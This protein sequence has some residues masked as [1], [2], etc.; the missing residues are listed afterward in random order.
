MKHAGNVFHH[1]AVV[2]L[3]AVIAAFLLG[4]LTKPKF[5]N[6]NY[7]PL[8]VTYQGFYEMEKDSVDVLFLGSSHA[9]SSFSPQELYN[10]CGIRSFNLSS[11][12][13]SLLVSYYWLKE[14][15]RTQSVKAVVLDT[16]VLFPYMDTPY[17]CNESAVRKALDPMRWS[18]VKFAAVRDL[19]RLD[20]QETLA[21][22]L[23]PVIRYHARWNDLGPNDI[24]FWP[25]QN[26]SLKGY[27]VLSEDSG[28][29]DFK[30]VVISDAEPAGTNS[31]MMEY[32]DKITAL[33]KEKGIELILVS[34]PYSE[35]T[36][37]SHNA[38]AAYASQNGLTF[39]NFNEA[40]VYD[41][42]DFDFAHDMADAGHANTSGAV[43]LTDYIGG[44]L[45]EK[46]IDSAADSQYETSRAYC[47][48]QIK[49][50]NLYRIQ[51][52]N[53]FYGELDLDEYLIFVTGEGPEYA[54]M[55]NLPDAVKG[56][57]ASLLDGDAAET[58]E[59]DHSSWRMKENL[60]YKLHPGQEGAFIQ[61][62][63]QR[64]DSPGGL[65]V[66]ILDKEKGYVIDHSC[67]N[68]QG[69]RIQ[70]NS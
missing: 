25:P 29:E 38:V 11:E 6:D 64:Y 10:T 34:T 37:A 51:D 21:S 31:R 20:G 13:Q 54:S 24:R 15:L 47:A 62:Y 52:F 30:P 41:R 33:C 14:A 59:S 53:E 56:P 27:A 23:F 4:E 8:D 22:F 49:N 32:L 1:A 68:L 61:V 70:P 66:V 60:N 48:R 16:I 36:D 2:L 63:D 50:A 43:K 46:G 44:V 9:I 17:N 58:Y 18:D 69:E 55:V 19:H 7:W 35:A 5:Y 39:I 42:L 57:F 45:K 28:I 40:S 12:E 65:Q 67:F 26:T 3:T